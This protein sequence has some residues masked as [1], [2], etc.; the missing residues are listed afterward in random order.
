MCMSPARFTSSV[1]LQ[2]MSTLQGLLQ[3]GFSAS[4]DAAL[5]GSAWRGAEVRTGGYCLFQSVTLFIFVQAYHFFL[6]AQR[7][8][9]NGEAEASLKTVSFTN[10]RSH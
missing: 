8:L 10:C 4:A 5:L 2:V 3:E 6:I 1:V 7:Q 9:Y